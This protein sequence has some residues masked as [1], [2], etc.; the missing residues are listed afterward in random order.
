MPQ[1][2]DGVNEEARAFFQSFVDFYA[3]HWRSRLTE[4]LK[5]SSLVQSLVEAGEPYP[6]FSDYKS[7]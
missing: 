4:V 6:F 1:Y 7:T 3:P 5:Y 2:F